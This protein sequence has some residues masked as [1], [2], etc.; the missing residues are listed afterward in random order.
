MI[1][2]LGLDNFGFARGTPKYMSVF[3]TN[4]FSH[5]NLTRSVIAMPFLSALE[6]HTSIT[7]RAS[8]FALINFLSFH[9]AQTPDFGTISNKNQFILIVF[10]EFAN[11]FP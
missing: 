8:E 2:T 9:L 10:F 1:T 6:A 3:R 5:R 7:K 11:F 4:P